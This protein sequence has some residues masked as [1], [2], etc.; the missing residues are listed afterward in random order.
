M[1]KNALFLLIGLL[2]A[3]SIAAT[4]YVTLRRTAGA[5]TANT[6]PAFSGTTGDT[7]AA[8]PVTIDS[9][10]NVGAVRSL[11]VTAASDGISLAV[12]RYSAGQTNN[13]FEVQNEANAMVAA[14]SATGSFIGEG[15]GLTLDASGFNGNLATTDNTLQEVAQKVDDLTAAGGAPTDVN[16]LVGTASGSLS[17]EIEV[18]TTPGGELGGT[19]ASPTLDDSITVDSWT[20]SA[21]T[22]TG[23]NTRTN[24]VDL[25]AGSTM[26]A[27]AVDVTKP[28]NTKS[29]S[30]DST[31]TFSGTPSA[32]TIFGLRIAN[33]DTAEHT[34]T[35]PSSYSELLGTRT[36]FAIPASSSTTVQWHYDGSL[37]RIYGDPVSI[38][39]LSSVTLDSANDWLEAWDA[40]DSTSKKV[41]AQ[42]YDADLTTWA[43]VTPGTGVATALAATTNGTGGV[44]TTDGTAVLTNKSITF[45]A[46]LGTDDTFTGNII[47]GLNNTGGVTQWNVVS[48]NS[49]SQWLH[50]D[51]DAAATRAFGVAVSTATTGNAVSVLTQGTVRND[52]WNWTVGG[53]VYL[54]T[55][56]S[57]TS[58]MTQ[59]APTGAS[60]VVQ[61]IGYA[62]TADIIYV[63][64]SGEYLEVTP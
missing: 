9:S 56:P 59:T 49:S 19:W 10:G 36:A 17:A 58:G 5:V 55:D 15:G 1:K 38:N 60:D 40:T 29:V 61:L 42:A 27:L 39:D 13:P 62:L 57:T 53:T 11:A 43:G 7:V 37:Y 8:T 63:N 12:R 25:I 21:P 16:Y 3:L 2:A 4:S 54:S 30:T 34:I 48:I 23:T 46:A 35:I 14:I 52:A 31:L 45:N 64:I 28:L 6:V 44:V 51:A 18:G 41:H 20:L 24:S 50:A 26:A 32:G 47:A 33:T 22:V